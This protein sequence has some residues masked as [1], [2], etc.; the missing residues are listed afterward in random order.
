M[1]GMSRSA[2]KATIETVVANNDVDDLTAAARNEPNDLPDS[3]ERMVQS[4]RRSFG[5]EETVELIEEV[6]G[7]GPIGTDDRAGR[8]GQDDLTRAEAEGFDAS[9]LVPERWGDLRTGDVFELVPL[10]GDATCADRAGQIAGVASILLRVDRHPGN[11]EDFAGAFR[12]LMGRMTDLLVF[13]DCVTEQQAEEFEAMG[14]EAL[15]EWLTDPTGI[16]ARDR[17]DNLIVALDDAVGLP[18]DDDDD[19]QDLDPDDFRPTTKG[20]RVQDPKPDDAW[21]G[22]W[23]VF[24]TQMTRLPSFRNDE[25][26]VIRVDT[27]SRNR[28]A[29]VHKGTPRERWESNSL[30]TLHDEMWEYMEENP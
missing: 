13:R 22:S 2:A 28:S 19:V 8:A 24:E 6:A 18:E 26:D 10:H 12:S 20:R 9:E 14:N 1:S 23:E 30:P 5:T 7:T 15:A 3:A 11:V 21:P 25:G 4:V 29:F 16:K 27:K 17:V